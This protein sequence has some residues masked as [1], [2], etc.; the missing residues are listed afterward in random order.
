M[1]EQGKKKRQ[2]YALRLLYLAV[3]VA[4]DSHGARHSLDSALLDQDFAHH[5][6]KTL[7]WGGEEGTGGVW[8]L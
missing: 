6:A 7:G 2:T 5:F 4:A 3:D 1:Q 8:R